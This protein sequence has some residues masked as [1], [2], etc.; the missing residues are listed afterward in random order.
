[1]TY[2]GVPEGARPAVDPL[3]RYLSYSTSRLM[4]N[5]LRAFNN[6]SR[7]ESRWMPSLFISTQGWVPKLLA[8]RSPPF[9]SLAL[10]FHHCFD[11]CFVSIRPEGGKARRG[12][13]PRSGRGD[14]PRSALDDS[15]RRAERQRY[16]C[17]RKWAKWRVWLESAAKRRR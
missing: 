8:N 12:P 1:M 17:S 2:D 6:A 14:D 10:I 9:A 7:S 16:I 15:V 11:V 5:L 3:L 4:H 13:S